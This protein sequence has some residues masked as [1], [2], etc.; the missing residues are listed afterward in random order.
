MWSGS[1]TLGTQALL[2]YSKFHTPGLSMV[3]FFFN[4][5]PINGVHR[6]ED[7]Y[8]AKVALRFQEDIGAYFNQPFWFS[9]R[10]FRVVTNTEINISIYATQALHISP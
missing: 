4:C 7:C 9:C 2:V 8:M 10:Q 3:F 1:L 5:T 6:G